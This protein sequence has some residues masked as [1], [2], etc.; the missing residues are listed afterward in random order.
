M[1]GSVPFKQTHIPDDG[2]ESARKSTRELKV[3][4]TAR[5]KKDKKWGLSKT[6]CERG[7]ERVC[8]HAYLFKEFIFQAAETRAPERVQGS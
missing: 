5:N 7:S 4:Q 2:D 8:T 3:W 6:E 1:F